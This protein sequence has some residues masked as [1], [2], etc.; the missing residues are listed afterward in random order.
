MKRRTL[1]AALLMAAGVSAAQAS[2]GAQPA[3]VLRC[4]WFDNPSPGNVTLTDRDGEWIIAEQGGHQVPWTRPRF[5][6]KDWVAAG[7][8][9]Y[10]H[11][12]ACLKLQA[13]SDSREVSRIESARARPLSACRTD[14]A[15][16]GKEPVA[17][18]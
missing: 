8:G 17:A 2:G 12:C 16:K 10:G 18:Q 6:A 13:D 4:G 15:L 7:R 9:S 5:A 1:C 3:A 14:P 11:G